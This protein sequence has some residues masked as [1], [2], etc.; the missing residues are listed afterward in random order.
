MSEGKLARACVKLTRNRG[1]TMTEY[2]MILAA[3]AV[4]VLVGYQTLGTKTSALLTSVDNQ[5]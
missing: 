2:A 4:V 3:I 5:F 1:Q